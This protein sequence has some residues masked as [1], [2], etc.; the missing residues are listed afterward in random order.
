MRM[1][2]KITNIMKNM[3]IY[4]QNTTLEPVILFALVFSDEGVYIRFKT[5]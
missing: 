4:Y 3:F 1:T 2:I 5:R